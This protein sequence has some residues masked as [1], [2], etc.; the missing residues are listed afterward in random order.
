MKLKI[1]KVKE[2]R[3]PFHYNKKNDVYYF[4]FKTNKKCSVDED[5]NKIIK[6]LIK[7]LSSKPDKYI[8][9]V[10]IQ[11]HN[12]GFRMSTGGLFS[13]LSELNLPEAYNDLGVQDSN[14]DVTE[15]A[16]NVF[17]IYIRKRPTLNVGK[18]DENNDCLFNAIFKAFNFDLLS[19]PHKVNTPAKLK[20]VLGLERN[21]GVPI[22]NIPE[23]EEYFKCSFTVFGDYTYMSKETKV[24]H[25]TLKLLNEH[26]TLENNEGR[27]LKVSSVK[28]KDVPENNIY[29]VQF[30]D[31]EIN[32]YD[33]YQVRV[34]SDDEYY[35]YYNSREYLIV[36]C[37][38]T[39]DI[40]QKRKDYIDSATYFKDNKLITLF[41]GSQIPRLTYKNI[42]L[43]TKVLS[44]P[45]EIDAVEGDILNKSFRGGL[46]YHNKGEYHDVYNYD[47]NSMYPHFMSSN[48]FMFPVKKPEYKKYTTEELQS[49][50][51]YPYGLFKCKVIGEHKLFKNT[52]HF[53]WYSHYD[54][55][56]FKLLGLSIEMSEDNINH[57]EY[58]STKR[59][60]GKIFRKYVEELYYLRKTVDDKYKPIVK[61]FLSCIWGSLAEKNKKYIRYKTSDSYSL[62]D[63][64]LNQ[65][66]IHDENTTVV[67]T[68]SSR[69]FKHDFARILFLTSYCRLKITEIL[70]KN[71]DMDDVLMVNTDGFITKTE[72]KS[73]KLGTELGEF[74]M[75]RHKTVVINTSCS[76][77]FFD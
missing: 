67:V 59:A 65:C 33:G 6:K 63:V 76:V 25:I 19:M 5:M 49:L 37:Q 24:K 30:V 28:F 71:F 34:I 4:R 69:I 21:D 56:R 53:E 58:D 10:N 22:E 77:Q 61:Q 62:Q 3:A 47:V 9:N 45:E 73:L 40:K 31:G 70:L 29:S 43:H 7:K 36:Y 55:T 12:A 20:K 11:F 1:S 14:V 50:R 32:L 52:E 26:Y 57:L 72:G 35:S 66:E 51:C 64:Y 18:S 44:N 74:K 39:D 16:F 17:D 42:M 23:L 48:S 13:T 75:S 46:H 54:L 38:P 8:Y 15:D 60:Y 27:S 2:G 41:K 68:D